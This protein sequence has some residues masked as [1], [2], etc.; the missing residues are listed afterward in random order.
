MN[1]EPNTFTAHGHT[2]TSHTPGDP[3]PVPPE[4]EVFI[5]IR[6]PDDLESLPAAA[7][8]YWWG[9]DEMG[10]ECEI[11]GWRYADEQPKQDAAGYFGE[12]W[13]YDFDALV[14]RDATTHDLVA[15]FETERGLAAARTAL[16]ACA[17]MADPAKEIAEL[18]GLVQN[19]AKMLG[20]A[21]DFNIDLQNKADMWRD[22]FE[23]IKA[24]EFAKPGVIESEIAGICDRALSDIR[25]N[26]SLIDQREKV[27]EENAELRRK[28]EQVTHVLGNVIDQNQQMLTALKESHGAINQLCEAVSNLSDALDS[29]RD[30]PTASAVL[31]YDRIEH[32]SIALAKLAPFVK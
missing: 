11:V 17:G 3:C 27:A 31:R 20:S 13:E 12:P 16:D 15:S 29:C 2:W 7:K 1:T 18:R 6:E 4:T 19:G 23:R 10:F 14:I 32:A 30:G 9:Q 24:V 22:E 26:I 25:S 21:L 28:G 5:M 8:S